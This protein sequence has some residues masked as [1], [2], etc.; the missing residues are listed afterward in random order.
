MTHASR[1]PALAQELHSGASLRVAELLCGGETD[2]GRLLEA[3][4]ALTEGRTPTARRRA[5]AT[6]LTR[7]GVGRRRMA[8]PLG[9]HRLL[10]GLDLRA[11]RQLLTYVV[12]LREPMLAGI[13]DE[14]LHPYFTERATP[15]GMTTEEFSAVNANG[16]FEVAGAITHAAVAEFVRRR[17]A[18]RDASATR[19]ALR[20]LG[21]GGILGSA[22]MS[23]ASG[24]C[25]GHFPVIGLPDIAC[26]AY[27]LHAV[28]ADEG[29]VR[30]DRV[31]AGLFV[32]LFL[33][34][35]IAVD[36]LLAR[37]HEHGLV[38]NPRSEIAELP[39]ASLEEAV[40]PI[41]HAHRM[42]R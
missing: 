20:V 19:R 29:R 17:Y 15:R 14:V 9:L 26:F 22:W 23:R 41:L 11:A 16:L 1:C 6:V 10:V 34:R 33:L 7:L 31:R 21:K 28:Y 4:A 38:R 32:R 8:R 5:A 2:R 37:A 18:L 13:V 12:A 42:E 36:Y 40:E 24:R 3:A 27:A 35:P 25:R 39:Y 30:V